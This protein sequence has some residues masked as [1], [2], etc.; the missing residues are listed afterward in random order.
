MIY[1]IEVKKKNLID[2]L[3]QE[4]FQTT[5]QLAEK[6]DLCFFVVVLDF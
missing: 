6:T 2:Y 4:F 5:S 3:D 1:I